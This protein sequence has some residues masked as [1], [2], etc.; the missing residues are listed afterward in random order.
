MVTITRMN[1]DAPEGAK[2][3]M[4][5]VK[6]TDKLTSDVYTTTNPPQDWADVA[7]LVPHEAI[8]YEMKAMVGSVEA[9]HASKDDE[10]APWKALYFSQ[11]FVDYFYKFVHEHHDAEELIY[12]PFLETKVQLPDKDE[13]SHEVLIF[14]MN[15]LKALAET[16]IEKK[17]IKCSNEIAAF[18]EKLGPFHTF[19]RGNVALTSSYD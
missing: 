2:K 3:E 11:W 18:H 16:M 15:E 7:F 12:F 9:L 14:Q 10:T 4:S 17:G 8:R 13:L 5:F 6:A 19:M 1:D